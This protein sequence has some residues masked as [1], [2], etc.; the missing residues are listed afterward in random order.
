M[1]ALDV[2][3][4][5]MKEQLLS[6]LSQVAVAGIKKALDSKEDRYLNA[7]QAAKHLNISPAIFIRLREEGNFKPIIYPG[8]VQPR[9][10][11]KDLDEF[12]DRNK[13]GS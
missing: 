12:A 13:V 6:E 9:Y 1:S 5:E 7:G 2:L 8:M 3:S 10:D 11:I 4:P